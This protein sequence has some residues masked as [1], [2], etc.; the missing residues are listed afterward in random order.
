HQAFVSQEPCTGRFYHASARLPTPTIGR[1]CGGMRAA[2][3]KGSISGKPI[4]RHPDDAAYFVKFSKKSKWLR[5]PLALDSIGCHTFEQM[6]RSPSASTSPQT[7]SW[8]PRLASSTT[9]SQNSPVPS[10]FSQMNHRGG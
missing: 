10:T 6:S 9:R 7:A 2:S 3:R 1:P 5:P 8:A 4:L